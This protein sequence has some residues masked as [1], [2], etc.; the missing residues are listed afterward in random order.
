MGHAQRLRWSLMLKGHTAYSDTCTF[1]CL[2]SYSVA[3]PLFILELATPKRFLK[4]WFFVY[5]VQARIH[6]SHPP[7]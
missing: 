1:A 2:D 5:P 7:H 6:F 3:V 4:M